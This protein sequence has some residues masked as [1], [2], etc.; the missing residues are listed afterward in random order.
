MSNEGLRRQLLED[1]EAVPY[2]RGVSNHMGSRLMEDPEKLE[3]VLTELKKKGLFFLDSRTTP[4]SV[5]V[6]V[7]RSVGVKSGER[8]VFLDHSQDERSVTQS[9]EQLIQVALTSGNAIGIG[10]PHAI[11]I[12]SLKKMIP[13]IQ[14]KGIE[15]VPLSALLE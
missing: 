13:K 14:E 8:N 10:H 1:I 12:K 3:I 9:L 4:Q 7:A 5:G 6:Q 15:I 2:I 11:T